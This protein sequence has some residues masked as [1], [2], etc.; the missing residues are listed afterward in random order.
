[1]GETMPLGE[2][3]DIRKRALQ[4]QAQNVMSLIRDPVGLFETLDEMIRTFR[5]A[6]RETL[7]AIRGIGGGGMASS[8]IFEVTRRARKLIGR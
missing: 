6:N 3:V 5:S 7:G 2:V 4:K 1:M 8:Q